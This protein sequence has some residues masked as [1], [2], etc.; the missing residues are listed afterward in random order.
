MKL[1]TFQLLRA[2][3]TQQI[4]IILRILPIGV[5]DC[6]SRKNSPDVHRNL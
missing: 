5:T 3:R 6:P 4:G 1:K 2:Q